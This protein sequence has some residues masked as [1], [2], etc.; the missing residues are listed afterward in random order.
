MSLTNSIKTSHPVHITF[1]NIL[2]EI[3]FSSEIYHH[4]R[5]IAELIHDTI[6]YFYNSILPF[7]LGISHNLGTVC[8]AKCPTT[9]FTDLTLQSSHLM[10]S[11][12]ES[13]KMSSTWGPRVWNGG[14]LLYLI[15]SV[16]PTG[17]MVPWLWI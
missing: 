11:K 13:T 14:L 6:A 15:N 8:T 3:I 5:H 9:L 12:G 4:F 10:P 1:F 2:Y 17:N 16:F 7:R